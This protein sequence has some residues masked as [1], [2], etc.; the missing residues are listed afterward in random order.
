MGSSVG[1]KMGETGTNVGGRVLGA[2]LGALP[3]ATAGERRRFHDAFTPPRIQR[4][5]STRS[6]KLEPNARDGV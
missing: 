5:P 6:T 3:T 4:V 2:Q 1:R